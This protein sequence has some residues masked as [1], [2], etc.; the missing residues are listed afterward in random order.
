MYSEHT[1]IASL[2]EMDYL[3]VKNLAQTGE[4]TYLEFKRTVPN[5]QKIAREMA[6]FANT[7]GGTLLIGVDDDRSLVGVDGYQEEEFLLKKAATEV[8]H[9]KVDITIEIVYFGE[10][11]LI[12]VRIPEASQKPVF[13]CGEKKSTVYL[14]KGDQNK[15]ASVERIR[16]LE[17]KQSGKSITFEYG[18]HE[19]TLFR[20][21]NEYSEISVEKFAHMINV[22]KQE[23]GDI[24]VNLVSAG[25][26]NLFTKDS[27]D[28]FTFSRRCKS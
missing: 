3:D 23:A 27:V 10:R 21:L 11:D 12:V 28:Y 5:A 13:I 25:I 6:A 24:L 22:S 19:Q 26:L 14:R 18:K 1:G 2:S 8:C 7:K 20:Y 9:P 4:G 17:N 15:I 16:I